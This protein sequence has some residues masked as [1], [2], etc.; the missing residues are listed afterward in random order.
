MDIGGFFYQVDCVSTTP[1]PGRPPISTRPVAARAHHHPGSG[2]P[3][4]TMSGLRPVCRHHT[5][6]LTTLERFWWGEG[7]DEGSI[8]TGTSDYPPCAAPAPRGYFGGAWSSPSNRTARPLEQTYCTPF[9]GY[10]FYAKAD[11]IHNDYFND[12]AP[13]MRATTGIMDPIHFRQ[14]PRVSPY[15]RSAFATGACSSGRTMRSHEALGIEANPPLRPADGENPAACPRAVTQDARKSALPIG[16]GRFWN[17][18][19]TTLSQ[20]IKTV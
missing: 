2:L 19:A 20:P 8:L 14:G 11:T 18:N 17:R 10:P 12:A 16:E 4:W 6:P 13:P 9:M 3:C 15:S 1:C 7:R 5:T